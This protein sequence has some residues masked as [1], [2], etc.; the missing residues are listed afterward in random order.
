MQSTTT[1]TD[2]IQAW[3]LRVAEGIARLRS[4]TDLSHKD[5]LEAIR[6]CYT[7]L[8]VMAMVAKGE[9][10]IKGVPVRKEATQ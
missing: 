4:A 8:M 7:V 10:Q 5:R 6:N 1:E 9:A 2:R 3:V